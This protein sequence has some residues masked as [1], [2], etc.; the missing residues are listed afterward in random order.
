M[1]SVA[2]G[3]CSAET[4]KP[5]DR[6]P[7]EVWVLITANAVIA[8]GY[9]V[10]APVLP[11][12]ARNFGVSISAATF[13]ITAFALMRLCA[14]PAS[15]VLVQRLGERRIYISG[16]LI[17]AVST[18]A[19]A[20]AQTYWQL[21]LFRSL[22][23][24]GSAMFTVSSLS[25]MIRISPAD[26]RGRVAGMF[27][28]AFLVGSVCGPVLGS[29]TVGLGLQMPF[30]IYGVALLIAAAVVFIKLRHSSLAARE[31]QTEPAI[32]VRTALGN[33]AYRA[34]LFS[35][36]ATGWAAFGLRIALVPLFVV[37]VLGRGAGMAGLALATFAVGNVSAVIPSGFLSDRIGRRVLL[38]CG[39][40][41]SAVATAL[42]GFTS[43]W[44]VF[45]AAAFVTGAAT[46]MFISPQQAA[47]ADIIGSK[48]RGGTAVATFQMMADF[49]AILGS[50]AVG[51]IAQHLSYSSAF[52]ISGVILLV[53]AV[54]WTFAPETRHDP[55][56]APTPGRPLGPEAG[57]EVP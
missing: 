23:G 2:E 47:V 5:K 25:L 41:V 30:V 48:A 18:G 21:L 8:L 28:S 44:P 12:Y 3:D 10:V 46:G 37:E 56:A 38:I 1:S 43:S 35:N 53:G 49:G 13:V 54:G 29:V 6:L 16:L 24:L 26:A 32:S 42:V 51:Q 17:V 22:G 52:V 31:E 50:L 55:R 9:G 33:T 34:A 27:S 7:S 40:T 57:G 14:A 4:D 45:L 15:G 20:F 39:L 19:C 11:Q 36:F